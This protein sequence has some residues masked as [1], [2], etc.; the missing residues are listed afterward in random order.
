[1]NPLGI[2]LASRMQSR[3]YE[4]YLKVIVYRKVRGS[5]VLKR[6]DPYR[7]WSPLEGDSLC[8]FSHVTYELLG[9]YTACTLTLRVC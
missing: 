7:R 5:R 9:C 1:M 8:I 3:V 2:H 4:V 6:F